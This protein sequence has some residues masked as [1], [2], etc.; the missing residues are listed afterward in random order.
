MPQTPTLLYLHGV[1]DGDPDDGWR[2]ALEAALV[3]L[4]Y[5][6]LANVNVVV[7]K[8]SNGLNG[9]DDKL[10]LPDLTVRKPRGDYAVKNRRDFER[11]RTSMEVLLGADERGKGLPGASQ[12][13]PVAAR[14]PQFVQMANYLSDPSV[15]AWVLQRVLDALPE[16]GRLVIVGHSLG[17]VIAADLIRRLPAALEVAG[18]VTIGSPLSHDRFRPSVMKNELAAPPANLAWWVNLWG[19]SDLVTNR[20]GVSHMFPWALDHCV[21]QGLEPNPVKAHFST[22]YLSDAAVAKAIGYGVFGSQSQE[23]VRAE[24]G[25]D[26]RVDDSELLVLLRLRYAHLTAAQLEGETRARFVD[27][28]RQ[29]QSD[30]VEGILMVND[31]ESRR[32][33]VAV[34]SLAVDLS[35]PDSVAPMP[36][37][38][39]R[40]DM[41]SAVL[42]LLLLSVEN[43]V[44]PFEID[45]DKKDRQAA[46][47]RLALDMG[48][49]RQ[50]G[51]NVFTALAAARKALKGPVNK[52]KWAAVGLGSAA[53]VV[54][55]GGLALS[56][57][58]T[59]AGGAA[60]TSA[61]AAF[62]PGGMIGGLLTAGTFATAGGG[63]IAVGLASPGTSADAVEAVVAV[64]L[65][66]AILREMQ[67]LKQDDR[68]WYSLIDT[69]TEV[70]RELARLE[71]LSDDDSPAVAE[72][73]KKVAA[74]GNALDYL[75]AH[76][77]NPK[78]DALAAE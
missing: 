6:G 22:T 61:L 14:L 7:P 78:Q 66:T 56:A 69:E 2:E 18:L 52:V 54:A 46:M 65:A 24:R 38:T 77:L 20:R 74:V 25:V 60:V 37:A 43:V 19:T 10:P 16:S 48:F 44:R 1:G 73:K 31:A 34:A 11:R 26:V 30:V 49:G 35:D 45:V 47:E 8:Y 71:V 64:Q 62:G 41:E 39:Q 50:F 29:S 67:G 70:S 76:G 68:L 36:D 32:T 59:L 55:T 58:P 27:A 12:V 63:G 9:V 72:I 75:R 42:P 33:P 17:S 21:H 28:V 3:D 13:A 15:R 5:D 40:L 23:I 57:A 51:A 53:L 4:G